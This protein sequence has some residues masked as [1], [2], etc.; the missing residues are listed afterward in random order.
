VPN[1][2]PI[3]VEAKDAPHVP[4]SDTRR[5]VE[6]MV[7]CGLD[8]TEIAYVF[9]T[10]VEQ[11][12]LHYSQQIEHGLSIT[13]AQVG[14]ALLKNAIKGDTNAQQFWLRARARWTTPTKDVPVSPDGTPA[15]LDLG[16][17]R[18][19]MDDIVQLVTGKKVAERRAETTQAANP[20]SKRVN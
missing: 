19:L 4:T 9:G 18:K 11:I 17:R 10:T 13:N 12:N 3:V 7:A 15:E 1:L 20:G 6:Q 16:D 5:M 2:V 14:A 8:A